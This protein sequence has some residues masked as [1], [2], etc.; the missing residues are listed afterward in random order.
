MNPDSSK[1]IDA[2]AVYE[3]HNGMLDD[4]NSALNEALAFAE[5]VNSIEPTESDEDRHYSTASLPR[6]RKNSTSLFFTLTKKSKGFERLKSVAELFM[7]I[8]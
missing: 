5:A 4:V 8:K 1:E 3:K 6:P 7:K 2:T